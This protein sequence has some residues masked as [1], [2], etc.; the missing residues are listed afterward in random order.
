MG[1]ANAVARSWLVWASSRLDGLAGKDCG[2]SVRRCR[3]QA[4]CAHRAPRVPSAS[5]SQGKPWPSLLAGWHRYWACLTFGS[6][7]LSSVEPQEGLVLLV[8]S[9][10]HDEECYKTNWLK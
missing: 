10:E 9:D 4:G 3:H 7:T 2:T 6:G 1:S 8:H 5:Q